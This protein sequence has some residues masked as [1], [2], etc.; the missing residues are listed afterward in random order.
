MEDVARARLTAVSP[1]DLPRWSGPST[2]TELLRPR[3]PDA[4]LGVQ[5]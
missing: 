1:A 4:I 5:R 2:G 3:R